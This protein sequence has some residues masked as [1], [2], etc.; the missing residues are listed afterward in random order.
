M[1][2]FTLRKSS[3]SNHA[4]TKFDVVDPDGTICG[5]ICV[6]PE[7]ASDLLAHWQDAPRNASAPKR[8]VNAMLAAKQGAPVPAPAHSKPEN[9]NPMV[10]AMVRAAK[11]HP[12]NRAAILRGC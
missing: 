8:A 12:L 11:K 2:T 4:A 5:R 7:E 10:A 1:T 3:G 6:P 9:A